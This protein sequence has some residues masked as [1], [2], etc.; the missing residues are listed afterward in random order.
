MASRLPSRRVMSSL[1]SSRRRAPSSRKEDPTSAASAASQ[2]AG[3]TS[4]GS[5]SAAFSRSPKFVHVVRI[6][7][8]AP[9]AVDQYLLDPAL[10]AQ[11]VGQGV[12]ILDRQQ[13]KPE[14]FGEGGKLIDT[15]RPRGIRGDHPDLAAAHGGAGGELG[16]GQRLSGAGRTDQHEWPGRP[17]ERER[18]EGEDAVERRRQRFHRVIGVIGRD[19]VEQTVRDQRRR[20]VTAKRV[21]DKIDDIDFRLAAVIAAMVPA[22]AASSRAH[23]R[24]GPAPGHGWRAAEAAALPHRRSRRSGGRRLPPR[25][26][27][28]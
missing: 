20:A 5:R 11:R 6:E 28:R 9:G 1:V 7:G 19:R 12:G 27:R 21:A 4:T 24:R 15:S 14:Q 25:A 26:S 2:P 23:G 22:V 13:L 10:D 16:D 17:A 3:R 8:I 18:L